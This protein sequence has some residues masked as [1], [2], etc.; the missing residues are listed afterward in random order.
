MLNVFNEV[1]SERTRRTYTEENS[2]LTWKTTEKVEGTTNPAVGDSGVV[3]SEKCVVT[4]GPQIIEGKPL[5]LLQVNCRIILNKILEFWSF[6]DTYN[7]DV[8]TGTE[9]WLSDETNNVEVFR[10]DYITFRRDRST[11][12]GGVFICVKNYIDCRELWMDDEFEMIAIVVK[13]RDPKFTWEFVG[14]YRAPNEDLR[15]IE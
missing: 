10:D 11:R 7:P 5:V 6:V 9:P 12:G 3:S 1:T 14:I 2:T 15:V 8:V 4:A 13:G